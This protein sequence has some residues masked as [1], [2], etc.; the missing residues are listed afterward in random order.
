MAWMNQERKQKVV[1]AA[2]PILCKYN[3]K[4]SF[5]TDRHSITL[6]LRSGS[7]DFLKD[8]VAERQ[9]AL[10]PGVHEDYHF[11]IN[12]YWYSEHYTGITKK[13]LDELMPAMRAADWYDRSDISTDYFDTAY[14]YHVRVG[15]WTSPYTL[16]N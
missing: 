8:V 6:T 13:F 3:V 7:L 1:A 14:Y 10:R 4:G 12:Q 2:K 11:D 15:T 9:A 16:S 5:K